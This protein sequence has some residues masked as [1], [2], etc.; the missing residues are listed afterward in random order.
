MSWT[1]RF[2]GTGAAELSALGSSAVV[3]ERDGEPVLLVDCGPDVVP[4]YW[5]T[6]GV[7]PKA[8]Y[9]THVHLDHV[10]GMESLFT[11]IRFGEER[12]PEPVIFTHAALVPLLQGRVADYPNVA[13][14][15]G[16]NFWDAFRLTPCSRGFWH[17]GLWFDVFPTRH[18]RPGTS[19]GIHLRGCFTF[20]G[21]TRPIPEVLETVAAHGGP[22]AHDCCLNGNPSHS[23]VEDIEREYPAKL[24]ERMML[25]HYTSAH[26]GEALRERGFAVAVPGQV[27]ELP[28][29]HAPHP[30]SG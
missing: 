17:E 21:D 24:R 27:V 18:H 26:D 10:G 20:T 2:L 11:R 16:S 23:G 5:D 7:A 4:R 1:L 13:A 8:L 29:P 19:Y 15:G 25:Y 30:D 12:F 22:I 6:Y 3:L 28:T 14:E 9:L